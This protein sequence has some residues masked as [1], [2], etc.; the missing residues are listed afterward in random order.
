MPVVKRIKFTL[1]RQIVL[2]EVWIFPQSAITHSNPN[3]KN[4]ITVTWTAPPSGMGAIRLGYVT[5]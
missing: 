1:N 4:S 3:D 5:S 2:M